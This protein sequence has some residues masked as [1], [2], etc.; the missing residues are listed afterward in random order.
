MPDMKRNISWKNKKRFTFLVFAEDTLYTSTQSFR[1]LSKQKR[2]LQRI[3]R[4]LYSKYISQIKDAHRGAVRK[5]SLMYRQFGYV[6]LQVIRQRS[7]STAICLSIHCSQRLYIWNQ[8]KR[9]RRKTVRNHQLYP[10][11][12]IVLYIINLHPMKTCGP[13]ITD[14]KTQ[15]SMGRILH[16]FVGL[17]R[18]R[19][20]TKA[21]DT[22]NKETF[23]P[24][25]STG[26]MSRN[27]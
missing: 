8:K 21:G 10:F 14:F 5:K 9:H 13:C 25:K 11:E 22:S 20:S 1:T 16:L 7:H 6:A 3:H 2:E 23:V 27:N 4:L 15:I 24:T 26:Q 18:Y 12:S 19:S 17:P